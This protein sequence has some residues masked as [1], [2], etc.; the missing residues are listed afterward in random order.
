MKRAMITAAVVIAALAAGILL[1]QELAQND[2][3]AVNTADVS[4]EALAF[5]LPDLDGEPRDFAEWHG[6]S[7]IVNFWATWCAPCRREIPL[8]KETQ[9]KHGD[10]GLQVIGIAVDFTEDVIAYA[11]DAQ[12]N[13][14]VLVG[15]EDAMAVAEASGVPFIGL[16][17]TLVV[18]ADGELLAAHMGEIHA[19][20]I[21]TIV[22]V[23]ARLEAGATDIGAARAEL[24]TL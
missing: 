14:P 17:F 22:D 15:Q 10:N 3:E 23:L 9:A 12:F 8:L 24:K 20:Q 18:T 13:Y 1:R 16:P 21:D 6:K 19:P 5:T 7:R 4:T 2:V 11:K